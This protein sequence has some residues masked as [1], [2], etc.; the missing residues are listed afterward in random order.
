MPEDSSAQHPVASPTDGPTALQL[1]IAIIVLGSSAGLTMYTKKTGSMLRS[2]KQFDENYIRNHPPKF[3][4]QTKA[5]NEKMKP[6]IDK[7]EF[8]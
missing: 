2:M 5:T 7:D 6:R 8:Y 3:G 4:P 1:G